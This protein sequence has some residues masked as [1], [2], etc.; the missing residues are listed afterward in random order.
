MNPAVFLMAKSPLNAFLRQ[1][2]EKLFHDLQGKKHK[3]SKAAQAAVEHVFSMLRFDHASPLVPRVSSPGSV[4]YRKVEFW[5]PFNRALI[6]A[7]ASLWDHLEHKDFDLETLVSATNPHYIYL[8]LFEIQDTWHPS[9]TP[10]FLHWLL[11]LHVDFRITLFGTIF[12]AME[13]E[14]TDS[15]LVFGLLSSIAPHLRFSGTEGADLPLLGEP[16]RIEF[17]NRFFKQFNGANFIAHAR[18]AINSS[19]ERLES[20]RKVLQDPP[21]LY[22]TPL[23]E[24]AT[25]KLLKKTDLLL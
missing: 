9:P 17:L 13:L 8:Y 6:S 23:S 5:I 14:D 22:K 1:N 11:D 2:P 16:H 15:D 7:L 20:A 25:A 4:H 10:V 21:F 3:L 19:K 12:Q 24:A 18:E